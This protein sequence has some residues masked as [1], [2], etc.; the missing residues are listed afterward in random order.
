MASSSARF[1]AEL[2]REAQLR[3]LSTINSLDGK[4]A[5]LVGF[6]GVVLGLIFTS[7]T[8]REDWNHGL[9]VGALVTALA[10]IVLLISILP[11]RGKINPNMI[12][13]AAAYMDAPEEDTAKVVVESINR[14]IV[15]NSSTLRWKARALRLGATLVVS[16]LTV[17]SL[18]LIYT[19]EGSDEPASQQPKG[20]N[21]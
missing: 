14:A 3:Q 11:R 2:A 15:S 7:S 1:I 4:A 19:L 12:A 9:S 10:I 5:T 18:S 16:G 8:A 6:A 13:L 21:R 17:M 20:T